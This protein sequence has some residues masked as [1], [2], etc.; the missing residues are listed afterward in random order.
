LPDGATLE[1]PA[2]RVAPGSGTLPLCRGPLQHS[3]SA[4]LRPVRHLHRHSRGSNSDARICGTMPYICLLKQPVLSPR[5]RRPAPRR[6]TRQPSVSPPSGPRGA[7]RYDTGYTPAMCRYVSHVDRINMGD[8]P[9]NH[10]CHT[11]QR[12]GAPYPQRLTREGLKRFTLTVWGGPLRE[13]G[14]AVCPDY[15]VPLARHVVP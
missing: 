5:P 3:S 9:G 4:G 11:G 14:P 1:Q 13:V 6:A 2:T 15:G 7:D 12:S 8:T 10:R